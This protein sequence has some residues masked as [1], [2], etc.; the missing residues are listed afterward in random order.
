MLIE[1]EAD[2]RG[3]G[4]NGGPPLV[5]EFTKPQFEL[6][7]TQF[8]F[9]A[10]V[11][12]FGA[13]KTEALVARAMRLKLEFP[14]N[15]IAYYLPTY[16]L[17]DRIAI[18]RFEEVLANYGMYDGVDFKIYSGKT[19]MIKVFGCGTIIF[20]TMDKPGRIIGYEVGDS[21]VDELDTLKEEDARLVWQKIIARNRQKKPGGAD[22]TVAVGTTPEGFRFVYDRWKRN[23]PNEQYHIIKASTYSNARNLPD[24]YIDDLIADYP[25]NLIAAYL[26]GEFV[27]LTSGAVYPEFSRALNSCNSVIMPGE[28]LHLGMDFNVGK[29][30]AVI[31]VQ[32]AGD[33]HAVGEL[34]GLLD[35][36]AMIDAIKR[37]FP[38]H[39]IFVYP[40]AS[41]SAR[42]TQNASVSDIA[43]LGQAGFT[44]LNNASN[45]AVKDRVLSMNRMIHAGGKRRLMVN[46]DLCPAFTEGLEKQA[47]NDKGEPDK[48][49]GFDHVVDGG[50]YFICY[51]FPVL[52]SRVQKI[53][54]GGV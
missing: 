54:I 16:D 38:N 40:D 48:T 6:I 8:R 24:N 47:Y 19:S 26:E 31:F 2:L 5:V 50:G 20:R 12:G 13:G 30:A 25:D 49:S 23:P 11:A 22:N 35:T 36:P 1:D 45:P 18:P 17:V 27:N 7:T 4:D 44:V 43:L 42:K 39:A 34:V 51:R 10:M 52:N 21:L 3:M 41:G 37:R 46:T 9:P 32:R 53:K 15:D 28:A 33:P 29:M 14:E